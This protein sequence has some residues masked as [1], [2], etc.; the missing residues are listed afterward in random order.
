[1]S[2]FFLKKTKHL[3]NFMCIGIR[4]PGTG[5][6]DSCELPYGCWELNPGPLE[7]Q[8]VLLTAEPFLQPQKIF[9][10]KSY[11]KIL[12]TLKEIPVK[13]QEAY[14]MP[15]RYDHDVGQWSVFCQLYFK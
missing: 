5:V 11:K 2:Y 14:K 6:T 4:S 8:S 7:E 10:T 13:V 1:M 12:L 9:S 3:F 15:N